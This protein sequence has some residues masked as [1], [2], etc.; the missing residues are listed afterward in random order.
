MALKGNLR[1]FSTTQL[2]N[3]INLARKTGALTIEGRNSKAKLYFKEGKLIHAATGAQN[4]QLTQMLLKAG[5][6]T[7]EQARAIQARSATSSDKELALLLMNAGHVSQ[8]DIIQSVRSYM[9][10]LVYTIFTWS[11]GLFHFEP[12]ALPSDDRITVPV[13]LE[14]VIME[15]SRRIKEYERLQDELPDLNMALKFTD[16]PDARL[17]KINL[18]VEE[19]RVISF[20]N[21]R[22]SIKQIAQSNNMSD[23]QVRK[24]VYGMLQAGLVELV[25]PEGV[26]ERPAAA[27]AAAP[28]GEQPRPAAVQVPPPPPPAVKRGVILRLIDRIKRI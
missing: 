20:I 8:T 24:I 21:P 3:L 19:W 5:K 7:A 13:D 26:A 12:N 2:L 11:D 28:R 14:N 22:N 4:G 23:F 6:L 1:D 9:L 15:G 18:S 25:R 27:A 16:R 17:R 10:E